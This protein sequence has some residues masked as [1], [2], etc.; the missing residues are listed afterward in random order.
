MQGAWFAFI[1][2]LLAGLSTGIGS[3]IAFFARRTNKTL[4]AVSLGF[5]AGVMIYISL[6][7]MLAEARLDLLG[8]YGQPGEWLALGAFF[9]GIGLTALVDLLVP[10]VENPHHAWRVEE[11]E[12]AAEAARA[13]KLLRTGM[14]T[15]MVLAL[16]NFPEG[17]ATFVAGLM[18]PATGVAIAMAIAIHNIPE[19]ISVSVPIFYA[20]GSRRKALLYSCLSGLCEP[21]G[22]AAGYVFLLR[23]VSPGIFGVVFAMVAGTMIFIA[24]D[25]LLP[26]AHEHGEH[27]HAIGGLIGGMAVMAV[28]LALV[29]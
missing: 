13:R 21:L 18:E 3:L 22:A 14:V 12:S 15:A 19:G 25:E 10:E 2:T 7:D 27:H 29:R 28:G 6:V 23:F 24:F 4:L 9:A 1:L 26:A 8:Q 5:S 17:I 16:H 20:T 11:M